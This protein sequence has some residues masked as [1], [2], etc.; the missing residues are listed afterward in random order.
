MKIK[1]NYSLRMKIEQILKKFNREEIE[2][3]IKH[4]IEKVKT[5]I[6]KTT[7]CK[8]S[9]FYRDRAYVYTFKLNKKNEII[10]KIT[11]SLNTDF[12]RNMTIEK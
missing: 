11:E 9:T 4:D 3:L 6:K 10:C 2:L 1:Y 12:L 8:T 7:I 5:Q